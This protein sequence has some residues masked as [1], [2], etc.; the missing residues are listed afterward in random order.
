MTPTFIP[1]DYVLADTWSKI[2]NKSDIVVFKRNFHGYMIFNVKRVSHIAGDIF[3][4]K[5]LN[6]NQ[7]A[8]IGDNSDNSED[9]RVF[10]AINKSDIVGKVVWVAFAY[11]NQLGFRSDRV[12]IAEDK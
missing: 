6:E 11:D 4:E 12:G 1:G 7:I 9:S 3:H 2:I 10:G 8:V 5:T